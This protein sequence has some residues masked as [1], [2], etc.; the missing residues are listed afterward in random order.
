MYR[1]LVSSRAKKAL[2][3]LRKSGAFP[4]EKFDAAIEC[5]RMGGS[6]PANLRDHALHGDL[7]SFREFHVGVDLLVQ[8]RREDL[9]RVITLVRVG[10][11]S[12][13]FGS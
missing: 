1:I 3:R 10:T 6:L 8:Y 12:E 5:L 4:L 13:L 11:H 7:A 2:R 9:A